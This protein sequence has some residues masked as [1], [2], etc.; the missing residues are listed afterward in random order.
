MKRVLI[1]YQRHWGE[2]FGQFFIKKFKENFDDVEI[3]IVTVKHQTDNFFRKKN[4]ISDFSFVRFFDPVRDYSSQYLGND[5][6]N[7]DDICKDLKIKSIWEIL[8]AT[9]NHIKNYKKSYNYGFTPALTDQELI[10]SI[11]AYYKFLMDIDK[12]FKPDFILIPNSVE[13]FNIM[14]EHYAKTRKIF[15]RQIAP[16]S[17]KGYYQFAKD[18]NQGGSIIE[19]KMKNNADYDLMRSKAEAYVQEFRKNFIVPECAYHDS[20]KLLSHTPKSIVKMLVKAG[21][22]LVRR[23]KMPKGIHADH[24]IHSPILVIRDYFLKI[25]YHNQIKNFSYDPMPEHKFVYFPLQM[26]PELAIDVLAP[27]FNNQIETARLIAMSLPSDTTLVVKDHPIMV[28]RR[29]PRYL[30]KIQSQPNIKLI[31]YNIKTPSILSHCSAVIATCG[32]IVMEAALLGIP[33]IQ[34]GNLQS[35]FLLPNVIHH[36]DLSKL[37]DIWPYI[38]DKK[39]QSP[40]YDEKIIQYISLVMQYGISTNYYE[41]WEQDKPG[42]LEPVWQ[43]LMNEIN[44]YNKESA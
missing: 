44:E 31:D 11:K 41:I 20:S 29:N 32:S 24:A 36:T 7:I 35:S 13:T 12:N 23:Q 15:I 40:E 9:R 19:K 10:C 5:N 21:M 43:S 42:D 25:H 14:L 2:I 16:T 3:G 17:V 26:Q 1:L 8:Q 39:L 37:S 28:G 27:Y 22:A 18:K 6:F 4:N 34:L 30:K 38:L 33:V